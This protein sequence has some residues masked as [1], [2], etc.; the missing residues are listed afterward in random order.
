VKFTKYFQLLIIL[1]MVFTM[2]GAPVQQASAAKAQPLLAEMAAHD[3]GQLL[4]VI[5]QKTPEAQDAETLV[6]KLGG[7]VT[8]DL[9]IINAV[10]AEMTAEAAV[11][12][13][14]TGSV[15][16]VSLD[17]PVKRSSV[18]TETLRDEFSVRS[19]KNNNGTLPWLDSWIETG[20]DNKPDAG[21]IKIDKSMLRLEDK[22]RKISRSA[23]LSMADSARLTFQYRREKMNS[24]A[25]FVTVEVSS[26]GG[27]NWVELGRIS[28]PANESSL[29]QPVSFDLTPHL[30]PNTKLRLATSST[31]AGVFW[32]DN[33]QIEYQYDPE[34]PPPPAPPTIS[35]PPLPPA[36][37][38]L[39]HKVEDDLYAPGILDF[40]NNSGTRNWTSRWVELGENDGP[41]AGNIRLAVNEYWDR[42]LIQEIANDADGW[43]RS[44]GIAR[45]TD[46]STA[47]TAVLSFSYKRMSM[48]G[49]DFVKLELSPDGGSTWYEAAR[50]TAGTDSTFQTASYNMSPLI[51]PSFVLRFVSD[52]VQTDS[53]DYFLLDDVRIAFDPQPLPAPPHTYLDTL[54]VRPLWN[55]GLKGTGVYVAIIDSGMA[56]DW[57]FQR[58]AGEP[59]NT[60]SRLHT[61]KS[62][63]DNTNLA[64]DTN[65][66]GTHVA[67][68][69]GGSG[70]KSNGLYKGIA[71]NVGFLSLKVSDDNG[72][73]Y[74]SDVVEA[75]QWVYDNNNNLGTPSALTPYRIRVVN[76]SLNSTVEQSYHTSPLSAAA[77]ILWFN[78]VVVIASAGNMTAESG[79]NTINAAP[80]NDPFIIT[81]GASDEYG[82]PNRGDDRV[83]SF[84]AYGMTMDGFSKP[85]IIAP[86]RNIISTLSPKSWWRNNHN[87]RFVDG[88]YF[89]ASG[90]SM[91]APMVTGA[92]A[93]LLQDEPNLTP[94]QV[95]YRL[96]Q[97][98]STIQGHPGDPRSYPYL[99]VYAAVTGTTTG[100]SNQGIMPSLML[101]SGPD[102]ID[103]TSVG[104]NSVGWNS[105]GWNS[106]GW[107][108]VGWNSVGWNSVGWNSVGWNSVSWND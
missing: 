33:I 73:A 8:R 66:H 88:L 103:F 100:S 50:F 3:P 91:A 20:D 93:L 49:D 16:W 84:S 76:L 107:N 37:T 90:T 41:K 97:T 94:D 4:R 53:A 108:S 13:A 95:K 83:A 35:L 74:E 80:A 5:V 92:V 43:T 54:N 81:V 14:K 52:F 38:V 24:S 11:E 64:Y 7:Q 42:I 99:D 79:Y 36:G 22:T 1:S 71:P 98:G 31:M 27:T 51:S 29:Q 72:M 21:K 70:Q 101:A 44:K 82:T 77:E 10:V 47:T 23:N 6:A 102:A 106:V 61:Q 25:N 67:G 58:L 2:A 40:R 57:D 12:L 96:L 45:S 19:Y 105:V 89:R 60:S 34:P 46:L 85:D 78:G 86:G 104:W 48:E 62:F 63:N 28:G 17:A 68:I 56:P 18:M 59:G 26:D 69:V 87:D 9:S 15:R 39:P 65:G 55:M 32:V 75:M 30:S